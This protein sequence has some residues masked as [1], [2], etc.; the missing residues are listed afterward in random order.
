ML[1]K[2]IHFWLNIF[3]RFLPPSITW[4]IVSYFQK[5]YSQRLEPELFIGTEQLSLEV[6][7]TNRNWNGMKQNA[8]YGNHSY[9]SIHTKKKPS[10]IYNTHAHKHK[11]F[12]PSFMKSTFQSAMRI[13]WMIKCG[14][15]MRTQLFWVSSNKSTC[16]VLRE[17][18]F[19][20]AFE[21]QLLI[22]GW[23]WEIV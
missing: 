9:C 13:M 4:C 10:T 17:F 22:C 12:Q 18:G 21:I 23:D 6:H 14:F 15:S 1:T 7:H 20:Y 16:F 2:P 19:R 3:V 11:A 8:S 5:F